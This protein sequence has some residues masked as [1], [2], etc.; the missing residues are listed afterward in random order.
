MELSKTWTE[1]KALQSS[2]NLLLQ[3]EEMNDTPARYFV[4]AEDSLILYTC[5]ILKG[6]ADAT[7]F[8]NN[9]KATCNQ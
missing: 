4:F 3:Y 6:T 1:L 5:K 7:D 9:Y 2:K 8:E